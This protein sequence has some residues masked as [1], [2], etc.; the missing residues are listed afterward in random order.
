MG[1]FEFCLCE[2]HN[3][4]NISWN[5]SHDNKIKQETLANC[6]VRV[7]IYHSDCCGYGMSVEHDMG[8][9]I[10]MG[11][12]L[13]NDKA[14]QK[15]RNYDYNCDRDYRS[16]NTRYDKLSFD[17]YENQ[18]IYVHIFTVNDDNDRDHVETAVGY[19]DCPMVILHECDKK[20]NK[21]VK[22]KVII[23]KTKEGKHEFLLE[24]VKE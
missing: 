20:K 9:A 11:K 7:S 12:D 6:Y 24:E 19:Y 17:V 4:K 8:Y 15:K 22:H 1:K 18:Y 5:M 21:I 3:N 14:I 16:M 13:E 2:Y 10:I 23:H